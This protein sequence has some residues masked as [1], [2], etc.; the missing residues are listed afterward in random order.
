MVSTAL[1]SGVRPHAVLTMSARIKS[2]V[3]P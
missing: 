3:N 1:S 2:F